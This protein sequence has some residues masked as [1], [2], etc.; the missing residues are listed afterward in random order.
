MAQP[1]PSSVILLFRSQS[2]YQASQ[3]SPTLPY[4]TA[5]AMENV[6]GDGFQIVDVERNKIVLSKWSL[7]GDF[8]GEDAAIVEESIGA[9]HG[10]C[11][12][13]WVGNGGDFPC[14]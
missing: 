1:S 7:G 2:Q 9:S 4:A 10:I 6:K 8:G 3:K 11:S 12:L 14:A 13:H 5:F